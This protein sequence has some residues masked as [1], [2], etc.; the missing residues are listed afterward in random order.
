MGLL[1]IILRPRTTRQVHRLSQQIAGRCL[2][3]VRERLNP[4]AG[5]ASLAEA[6]GY[7]RA[8]A[9][10]VITGEVDLTLTVEGR[11]PR[12]ARAEL[13]RQSTGYVVQQLSRE[14]IVPVSEH[15]SLRRAA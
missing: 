6:R 2:E 11:L 14:M 10:L 1:E 5:I 8:R 9:A 13:V 3:G 15:R 12:W 7:V 4:L